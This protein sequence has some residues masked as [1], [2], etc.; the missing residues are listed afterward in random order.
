MKQ[1]LLWVACIIF[2][3]TVYGQLGG[4]DNYRFLQM[5]NSARMTG[6]GGAN[7]SAP[8]ADLSVALYNPALLTDVHHQ[9]LSFNHMFF[10][11]G[12]QT[13]YFGYGHHLKKSRWTLH[14]AF[15]YVN[16][17]DFKWTDELDTDLGTFGAREFAWTVGAARQ[18]YDRLTVGGNLKLINSNFETYNAFALG[19]DLGALYHI[20]ESGL[21]LAVAIS[22]IGGT[23]SS[24]TETG[25]ERMPYDVRLGISKRLEKAPFRFSVTAHN[26]HR[27]N[28]LYDNPENE[29]RNVLFADQ[30]PPENPVGMFVDNFFRHLIFGTEVLIGKQ[31]NFKIHVGY[32]H[33]RRRELMVR[34]FKGIAGFSGG[35]AFNVY[36]FEV[37]YGFSAFHLAGSAHHL[38]IV[39]NLQRFTRDVILN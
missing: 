12:I 24:Y 16:Y 36:K 30:P 26:L 10:F 28:L 6:L 11:T 32:N 23:L 37:G 25:N 31:E 9:G 35:V 2:T 38:S 14:T 18:V 15:Q 7:I 5:A 27:W 3:H 33:F 22:N 8:T 13:G 20:E 29:E 19:L 34:D 21:S 4:R 39:T 1:I 17:G